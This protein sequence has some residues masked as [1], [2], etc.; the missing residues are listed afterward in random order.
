MTCI[1]CSFDDTFLDKIIHVQ[2]LIVMSVQEYFPANVLKNNIQFT[3]I[4]LIRKTEPHH[5]K[6]CFGDSDKLGEKMA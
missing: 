3:N 5:E 6:T 1:F 2:M 4:S